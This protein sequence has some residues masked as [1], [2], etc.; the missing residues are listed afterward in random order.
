MNPQW[1]PLPDNWRFKRLIEHSPA[2][3]ANYPSGL[4]NLL[5][6]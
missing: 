5:G 6:Q 4:T 3:L 2:S 1:R